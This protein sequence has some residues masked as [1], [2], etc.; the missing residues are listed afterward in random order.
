MVEYQVPGTQ[1]LS[2]GSVV[3]MQYVGVENCKDPTVLVHDWLLSTWYSSFLVVLPHSSLHA[4]RWCRKLQWY[5]DGWL[6]RTWFSSSCSAPAHSSSCL[7]LF[8]KIARVRPCS[9]S[10]YWTVLLEKNL[11]D[12][13]MDFGNMQQFQKLANCL[14]VVNLSQYSTVLWNMDLFAN[15]T[16][17]GYIAHRQKLSV[18]SCI[19]D[20][21]L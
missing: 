3:F 5:D 21:S 12:N 18:N 8:S 15:G 7:L 20:L 17:Y 19:F 14:C 11:F 1:L 10:R 9:V 2:C 6:L 16:D 4:I 13:G